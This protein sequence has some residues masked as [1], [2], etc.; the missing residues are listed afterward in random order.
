M[1]TLGGR[2]SGIQTPS[3]TGAAEAAA[4]RAAVQ[5][6]MSADGN[7]IAN[8]V[9]IGFRVAAGLPGCFREISRLRRSGTAC[10]TACAQASVILARGICHV[11]TLS[12][13]RLTPS[14]T[15]ALRGI[16]ENRKLKIDWWCWE[17]EGD[18]GE[19]RVLDQGRGE[20]NASDRVCNT[21]T[22]TDYE[23]LLPAKTPA[24]IQQP[25]ADVRRRNMLTVGL[26]E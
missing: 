7:R 6:A 1:Q 3:R 19:R 9:A 11:G 21:L 25:G 16:V 17:R 24:S 2:R 10:T 23:P 13:A 4:F 8:R 20:A 15:A 5:P 12:A 18:R 14:N 26:D 22:G